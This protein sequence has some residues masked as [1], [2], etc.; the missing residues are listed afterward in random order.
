M[1]WI[2]TIIITVALIVPTTTAASLCDSGVVLT[3]VASRELF[4]ELY[5]LK[6]VD[7]LRAMTP[8]LDPEAP[9]C[10][11]DRSSALPLPEL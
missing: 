4:S 8:M 3:S 7:M 1:N 2:D 6:F 5:L 9:S 10:L 11:E